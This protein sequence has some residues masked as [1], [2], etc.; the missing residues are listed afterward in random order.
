MVKSLIDK[1]IE[2]K[3]T[4]EIE[5]DDS[6]YE[7]NIYESEF[8]DVDVVFAIGQVKYTYLDNKIVYYPI[9]LIG[10]DNEKTQIGVY[11]L[12]SSEQQNI[13]DEDG[14]VDLNRLN[15][16]L[17]YS[18]AYSIISSGAGTGETVEESENDDD[19]VTII[20]KPQG[21]STQGTSTQGTQ[22]KDTGKSKKSVK[23]VQWIKDFM[24]KLT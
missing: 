4:T 3:E 18:N 17:F 23:Q 6:G 24:G 5:S 2:Y 8:F 13:V 22:G 1:A 12:L 11:E 20:E 16:P 14:D 19:S 10:D 7:A 9:Y 15:L 21:T